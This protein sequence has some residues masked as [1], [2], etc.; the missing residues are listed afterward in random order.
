MVIGYLL[1]GGFGVV[2]LVIAFFAGPII[3]AVKK[4]VE[5]LLQ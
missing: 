3:N 5:W 4:Q 2:T 1:G